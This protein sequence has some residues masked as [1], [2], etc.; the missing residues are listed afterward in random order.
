M[1]LGHFTVVLYWLMPEFKFNF[2]ELNVDG[3]AIHLPW[4]GH[5]ASRLTTVKSNLY[6]SYFP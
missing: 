4:L 1:D 5:L 6:F 3:E 2:C